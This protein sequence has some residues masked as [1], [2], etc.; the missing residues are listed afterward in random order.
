MIGFFLRMV[1]LIALI[2]Q[3]LVVL[4]NDAVLK[5]KLTFFV[6]LHGI[7]WKIN[8]RKIDFEFCF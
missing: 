1:L 3:C 8:H 7:F 6:I 4:I 5:D 2:A